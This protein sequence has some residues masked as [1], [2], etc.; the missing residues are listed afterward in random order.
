MQAVGEQRPS[1]IY[2]PAFSCVCLLAEQRPPRICLPALVFACLSACLSVCANV[3]S[4][5]CRTAEIA[6][7]YIYVDDG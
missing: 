5:K 7:Y 2:M 6:T 1:R 3:S 4:H